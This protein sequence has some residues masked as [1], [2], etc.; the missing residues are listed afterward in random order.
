M[1]MAI[2]MQLVDGIGLEFRMNGVTRKSEVTWG[3]R[4]RLTRQ[5]T[6]SRE[7]DALWLGVCEPCPGP[8][9]STFL[10]QLL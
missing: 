9:A 10:L 4:G 1:Q 7:C 8:R 3:V 2:R 5:C 6:T